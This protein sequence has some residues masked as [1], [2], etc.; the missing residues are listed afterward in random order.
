M[1]LPPVDKCENGAS[2]ADHYY[3]RDTEA[4]CDTSDGGC[5]SGESCR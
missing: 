4:N 5:H 1:A 2:A 3:E